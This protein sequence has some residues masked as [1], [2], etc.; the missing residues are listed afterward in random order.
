VTRIKQYAN[1]STSADFAEGY[2]LAG[3]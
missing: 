3:T 1:T 2:E